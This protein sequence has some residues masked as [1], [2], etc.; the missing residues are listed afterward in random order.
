MIEVNVNNAS[1]TYSDKTTIVVNKKSFILP[2]TGKSFS[3][4]LLILGMIFILSSIIILKRKNNFQN[5]S[6]VERE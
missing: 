3:I 6:D 4:I 1:G 5:D 2:L